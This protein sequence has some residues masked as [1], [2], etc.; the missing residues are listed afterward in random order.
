[1][2][3]IF[4]LLLPILGLCSLTARA[5]VTTNKPDPVQIERPSQ[6]LAESD[7]TFSATVRD[8]SKESGDVLRCWQHGRL[9]YESGGFARAAG[10]QQAAV[11]TLKRQTGDAVNVFSL[12]DGLCI[13]S[14]R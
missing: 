14:E 13:L 10:K 8:H 9:L 3:R 4:V 11:V 2:S 1:M 7:P 6:M 5:D 12:Q